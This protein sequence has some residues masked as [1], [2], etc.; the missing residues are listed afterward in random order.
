[1]RLGSIVALVLVA[2][3]SQ[4]LAQTPREGNQEQF[5]SSCRPPLKFVAGACA[6]S[7]PAGYEDRGR[8]CVY[9]GGGGGGGP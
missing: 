7:C 8:V 5:A 4:A 2:A 1:M 9:R 3:G 6:A